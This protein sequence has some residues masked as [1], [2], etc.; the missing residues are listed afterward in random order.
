MWALGMVLSFIANKGSHLFKSKHQTRAW[1]G[2]SS[3]D[4]A[5]YSMD[6]RKVVAGLLSPRPE[7]RPTAEEVNSE[8]QKENRQYHENKFTKTFRPT[9]LLHTFTRF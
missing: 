5:I 1:T 4:H 2:E 9:N 7:L 3:L 6:L 8:S